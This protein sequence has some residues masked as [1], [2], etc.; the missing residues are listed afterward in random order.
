M[1]YPLFELRFWLGV[2][3]FC[4]TKLSKFC[5]FLVHACSRCG[6]FNEELSISV[7]GGRTHFSTSW[8]DRMS[9]AL[10]NQYRKVFVQTSTPSP[11]MH[12]KLTELGKHYML[13]QPTPNKLKNIS[14]RKKVN[15]VIMFLNIFSK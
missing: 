6:G 10:M 13:K 8:H 11:T 9:L 15:N 3:L 7:H 1:S 2:G 12:R 4:M 5:K 14:M